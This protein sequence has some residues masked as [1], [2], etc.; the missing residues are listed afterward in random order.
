V[1]E[2]ALT[3]RN[4]SSLEVDRPCDQPRGQFSPFICFYGAFFLFLSFFNFFFAARKEQPEINTMASLLKQMVSRMKGISRKITQTFRG[5]GHL[6]DWYNDTGSLFSRLY[7]AAHLRIVEGL[8]VLVGREYY[9]IK[10]DSE[11]YRIPNSPTGQVLEARP[12]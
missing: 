12:D 5:V 4:Y 3:R 1:S 10:G 6:G 8:A 2:P 11:G 9:G 7:C